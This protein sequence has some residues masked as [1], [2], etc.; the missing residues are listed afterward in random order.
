M[1]GRDT[2]CGVAVVLAGVAAEDVYY[3]ILHFLPLLFVGL[4]LPSR[5]KSTYP[6]AA[7]DEIPTRID[8]QLVTRSVRDMR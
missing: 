4:G 2:E 6:I 8:E 1:V 5:S 3:P 7:M